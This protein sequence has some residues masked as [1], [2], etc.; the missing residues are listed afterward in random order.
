L[1]RQRA[2]DRITAD[3]TAALQL[4]SNPV[5]GSMLTLAGRTARG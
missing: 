1:A 4:A 2:T 5:H 3:F